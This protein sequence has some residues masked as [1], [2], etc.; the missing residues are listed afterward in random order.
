MKRYLT[1]MLV[2]VMLLG[3][4]SFGSAMAVSDPTFSV[5]DAQ[6]EQGSEFSVDINISNNPGIIA[7]GLQVEY[8]SSILELKEANSKDFTGTTFGPTSANP[9]TL[10]WDGSLD[11]NN[12]T[13][14]AIA[15]LTFVVKDNA[16]VGD[17]EIPIT[18]YPENVFNQDFEKVYY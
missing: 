10:T 7:L 14:G 12:T 3:T 4:L 9:F 6:S 13:N 5:T 18:Y 15:Q 2:C 8:D 17:T 16:T 1:L 11:P